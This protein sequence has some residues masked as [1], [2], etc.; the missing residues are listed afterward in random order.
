[1]SKLDTVRALIEKAGRIDTPINEA[2]TAALAAARMIVKEG[3]VIQSTEKEETETVITDYDVPDYFDDDS[4]EEV[5]T[6]ASHVAKKSMRCDKC[7]L[8]IKIGA[9]YARGIQ[10]TH[11]T[12]FDCRS[13]FVQ[14][15]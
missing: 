14:G 5:Q 1:M 11:V 10:N 8:E 9:T 15:R 6:F 3:F 13:Y 7:K 4:F 12:H 2:R